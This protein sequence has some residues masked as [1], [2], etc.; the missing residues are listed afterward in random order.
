MADA[1][2][3]MLKG[4]A[5]E[6]LERMREA[7]ARFRNACGSMRQRVLLYENPGD[8][9][10]SLIQAAVADLASARQEWIDAR[11]TML[12]IREQLGE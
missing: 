4:R 12:A 5:Q 11:A 3:L 7:D 8:V 2:R 6:C 1:E 9:D 10:M